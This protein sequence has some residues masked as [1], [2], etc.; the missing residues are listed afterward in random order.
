MPDEELAV[1]YISSWEAGTDKRKLRA[2][3][4]VRKEPDPARGN[5]TSSLNLSFDPFEPRSQSFSHAKQ[6]NSLS[7]LKSPS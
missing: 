7:Q 2:G 4:E 3:D 5:A 6:T 1:M